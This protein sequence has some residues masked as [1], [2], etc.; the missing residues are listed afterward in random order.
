MSSH[1]YDGSPRQPDDF[2]EL[3]L[4]PT[5]KPVFDLAALRRYCSMPWLLILV[6]CGFMPWCSV[7]CHARDSATSLTVTQS[8]Y[9]AFY[10]GAST[11]LRY[12]SLA[13]R[14]PPPPKHAQS[15]AFDLQAAQAERIGLTEEVKLH[16]SDS[17]SMV[18]PF[19]WLFWTSAIGYVV[20]IL[21]LKMGRLRFVVMSTFYAVMLFAFVIQGLLGLPLERLAGDIVASALVKESGGTL[22]AAA[23]SISKTTWFWVALGAV[24]FIG[25]TEAINAL[26]REVVEPR[27]PIVV[28]VALWIGFGVVAFSGIVFQY[29]LRELRLG[30][31]ESRVAELMQTENKIQANIESKKQREI[32]AAISA[33]REQEE[34][35]RREKER[36]QE[37][38]RL[39]REAEE[40]E[41]LRK[42][43]EEQERREAAAREAE[44]LRF[45]Q[46]KNAREKAEREAREVQEKAEREARKAKEKV[47]QEAKEAKEALHAERK[48]GGY[49][50][51]RAKAIA[52]R[53]A[54]LDK[55]N[56]K[57]TDLPD[58]GITAERLDKESRGK[59]FWVFEGQIKVEVNGKK[60]TYTWVAMPQFI[61]SAGDRGLWR[62]KSSSISDQKGNPV[63]D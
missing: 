26:W 19:M 52:Y 56:L 55:H 4:E 38:A 59:E 35:A 30:I 29:G 24:L 47:E 50:D 41:T 34:A 57:Y 23:I 58:N 12:E 49:E 25:F 40:R 21:L 63:T 8:G 17:F 61:P 15:D 3:I 31:K 33:A 53:N 2:P 37:E 11:P 39:K 48:Y 62:C 45:I 60:L 28:P 18:S 51:A 9:Q 7:G 10:G 43:K 54:A 6:L 42:L 14:A 32:D 20:T 46:E 22:A 5:P 27:T 1:F 16:R 36:L 44:R 13:E